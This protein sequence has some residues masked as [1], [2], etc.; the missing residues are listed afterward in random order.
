MC[1]CCDDVVELSRENYPFFY[2][3]IETSI[4]LNADE[5]E[6]Y[7]MLRDLPVAVAKGIKYCPMC[8]R[9]LEDTNV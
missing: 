1:K 9:K 8:G 5:K 4:W 7:C 6:I 2:E 3:R